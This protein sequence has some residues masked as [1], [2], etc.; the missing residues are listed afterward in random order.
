LDGII[1]TAGRSC[2]GTHTDELQKIAAIDF[3]H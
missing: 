3:G 1:A 2:A